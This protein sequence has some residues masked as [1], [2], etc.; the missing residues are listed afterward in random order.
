M[1][2]KDLIAVYSEKH[3]RPINIALQIVKIAGTY[4]YHWVFKD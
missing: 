4:N 1:P 3:A 2:F